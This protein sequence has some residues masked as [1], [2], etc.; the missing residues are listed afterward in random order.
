MN[1]QQL[2]ELNDRRKLNGEFGSKLHGEAPVAVGA[3]AAAPDLH[4]MDA[5]RSEL[6]T[7]WSDMQDDPNRDS[8]AFEAL[9]AA[10]QKASLECASAAVLAEY[11]D[12]A[13]LVLKENEDGE[14]QYEIEKILD[15]DGNSLADTEDPDFDIPYGDNGFARETVWM[16][17]PASDGWASDRA[18]ITKKMGTKFAAV[19][20]K[21]VLASL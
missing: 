17:D 14:N 12:A 20:L 21:A 18:V 1:S 13:T 8:E 19:D 10:M 15:E 7:Q 9:D 16:L 2:N 11:P 5:A 6:L 3:P 4:S